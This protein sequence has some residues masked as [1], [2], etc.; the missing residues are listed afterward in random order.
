[1]CEQGDQV[2]VE[3]VYGPRGVDRCIAPLVAALNWLGVATDASCC[4]H[5]MPGNI[6]LSDGRELIIVSSYESA[7]HVFSALG[8]SLHVWEDE[9]GPPG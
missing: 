4:G 6:I 7:R 3:T 5:G 2:V 8:W 1:M 9:H